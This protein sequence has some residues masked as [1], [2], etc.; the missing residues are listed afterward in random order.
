MITIS[1]YKTDSFNLFRC[2]QLMTLH[3]KIIFI[4]YFSL[5]MLYYMHNVFVM[6]MSPKSIILLLS[7]NK[8]NLYKT[9]WYT[10]KCYTHG[11]VPK[12]KVDRIIRLSQHTIVPEKNL[13]NKYFLQVHDEYKVNIDS[14]WTSCYKGSKNSKEQI[15]IYENKN[16]KHIWTPQK[17]DNHWT[18]GICD[19][20]TPY[21]CL[22]HYGIKIITY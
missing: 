16:K 4:T 22:L 9:I 3:K 12:Y 7:A 1:A 2:S 13:S 14:Q 6:I 17:N 11:F 8:N 5:Y 10:L 19:C 20:Y 15:F 21:R 18:T